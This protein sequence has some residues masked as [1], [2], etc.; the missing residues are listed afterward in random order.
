MLGWAQSFGGSEPRE[1]SQKLGLRQGPSQLPPTWAS[2]M[3]ELQAEVTEGSGSATDG[4]LPS[5]H[6]PGE[7]LLW[8]G[9]ALDPSVTQ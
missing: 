8:A 6:G 1:T 4:A 2:A 5:P 3:C 9:V 7:W